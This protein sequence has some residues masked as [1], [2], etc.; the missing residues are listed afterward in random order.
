MKIKPI[1]GR[2]LV[3]EPDTFGGVSEG[4]I[5]LA[6]HKA[7]NDTI[8]CEVVDVYPGCTEIKPG[9]TVVITNHAGT[10]VKQGDERLLMVKEDQVLMVL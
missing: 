10:N 1:N 5:V 4:G 7:Q 2:I 3:K 9:D 6:S 8:H